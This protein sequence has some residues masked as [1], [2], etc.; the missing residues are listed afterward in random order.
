[1]KL[2]ELLPTIEQITLARKMLKWNQERFAQECNVHVATIKRQE[3]HNASP[4]Y[5]SIVEQI[6]MLENNGIRFI[7]DGLKIGV[8][9]QK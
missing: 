3:L 7:N 1:M 6:K 4:K 2:H 5:E 9:I 8:I